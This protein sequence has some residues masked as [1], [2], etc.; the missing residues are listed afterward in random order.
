[1]ISGDLVDSVDN[2]EQTILI[3][4]IQELAGRIAVDRNNIVLAV[5]AVISVSDESSVI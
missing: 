3:C 5:L 2:L 1:M 4:S